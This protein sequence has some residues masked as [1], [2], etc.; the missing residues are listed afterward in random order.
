M[1]YSGSQRVFAWSQARR[2]RDNDDG[3][4]VMSM[5]LGLVILAVPLAITIMLFVEGAAD[6]AETAFDNAVAAS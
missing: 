4:T 2:L 6:D 1:L 3:L 5:A